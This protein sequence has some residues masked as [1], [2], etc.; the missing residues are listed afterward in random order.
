MW[1]QY[2]NVMSFAFA[3]LRKTSDVNDQMALDLD[4]SLI[5]FLSCELMHHSLPS[6]SL[7][8]TGGT[9]A[10]KFHAVLHSIFLESGSSGASLISF[11]K[12]ICACTTDL[13]T[14]FALPLVR[15]MPVSSVFPWIQTEQPAG[16]IATDADDFDLLQMQDFIPT[17]VS[18]SSSLAFPGL[19]HIIHNAASEVL[20][21]TEL[22]ESQV[23][24]LAKVCNLLADG[25][26]C[27]KMC[28]TCYNSSTGQQ[29]QNKLKEFSC[30]VY[31]PRWGSVAF[32][33]RSLLDVKSVLQWGWSLEK[34]QIGGGKVGPE[35]EAADNAIQSPLF[36]ASLLVLDHLYELIR[37]CFRWSEGCPCHSD[38]QFDDV[39]KEVR[40]R[41]ESCPLRGLRVP[42][43][44][45]GDF[46]AVFEKLQNEATVS[47]AASLVYVSA[48]DKGKLLQEFE[49]G[50]LFLLH[51]FTLK[52]SAFSTP[53]LLL[54]AVA[55]HSKLVA[56]DSIRICLACSDEHPKIKALQVDPLK[57]QAE[58]Y[59][60]GVDLVELPEL[61]IFI[62]GLRFCHAVERRVEGGHAK[63]LRRGRSATQHTEAFDSLALRISE[64]TEKL[65][66]NPDFLQEL[67]DVIDRARSPKEL[68]GIL[69]FKNHPACCD[70]QLHS[71][72]KLYRQIVYRADMQTLYHIKPP[73]LALKSC[74]PDRQCEPGPPQQQLVIADVDALYIT[75]LRDAAL[76]FFHFQL[77][78]LESPKTLLIYSCQALPPASTIL[79][80]KKLKRNR[81]SDLPALPLMLP[82]WLPENGKVWFSIISTSPH[83]SKRAGSGGLVSTDLAIAVHESLNSEDGF[84]YVL[85]TAV[86][87]GQ[88]SSESI[89]AEDVPLILTT[90]MFDLDALK[91][92]ECWEVHKEL[93]YVLDTGLRP[94]VFDEAASSLAEKMMAS[95]EFQLDNQTS[96]SD[97]LLL[98]SWKEQG[99]VKTYQNTVGKEVCCFSRN[100]IASLKTCW[101]LS[102]RC[103]VLNV[104]E[105]PL[106][107][108]TR[109][110]LLCLLEKEGWLMGTAGSGRKLE[111]YVFGSSEPL[112][113]YIKRGKDA[114]S[115]PLPYL[116]LLLNAADHGK[117]VPHLCAPAK[118]N[119]LLETDIQLALMPSKRKHVLQLEFDDWGLLVPK[120][121][122]RR[123]RKQ[124]ADMAVDSLLALINGDDV[125]HVDS[126]E[127]ASHD[128]SGSDM[129][130]ACDD[131]AAGVVV[132]S[133]REIIPKTLT[134]AEQGAEVRESCAKESSSLSS[135]SSDSS[136]DST[137]SS[138]DDNTTAVGRQERTKPVTEKKI[139]QQHKKT[140]QG[141]NWGLC[142]LTPRFKAKK[143]S[144]Y[145]MFCSRPE[146][147]VER[148]C[149]K[150][151][152]FGVAGG[153]DVCRRM[154]KSWIVF[155]A[156][157]S[158]RDEHM[159][160][161]WKM[162]L[163]LK[164]DL[165]LPFEVLLDENTVHDWDAYDDVGRSQRIAPPAPQDFLPGERDRL[166]S[167]APG[168]PESVHAEMEELAASGAVPITTQKQRSRNKKTPGT[169]YGV[170]PWL[171]DAVKY[172]YVHP[173]LPP[174]RGCVWRFSSGNTW[175]L[176]FKGG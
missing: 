166:G 45:A 11:C 119:Q 101:K 23:D 5:D 113:W 97:S 115:I 69:G 16:I 48:A 20:T 145:Q 150:E 141:E 67:S 28:E 173:N 40:K 38:L 162:I 66:S 137:D 159:F 58:E 158:S 29:L 99:F 27:M 54:G 59:L 60:N 85:S 87:L 26:S 118:Y 72:D 43:V 163:N 14:E 95:P 110:E 160:S 157:V 134:V 143:L 17:E 174:P 154:L 74:Q 79:L 77:K 51:T 144:G 107:D 63:V 132:A 171:S 75:V 56:H 125:E 94:L 100:G 114:T 129:I 83:R 140:L 152:S 42:E 96:L 70:V 57:W 53:P 123:P 34:Y 44:C 76:S 82:D 165:A 64:I 6:T 98:Q 35:L 46:F 12:D 52:L 22:L 146:H 19:L 3:Q 18:L 112:V 164:K 133:G 156:G 61:G 91:N 127:N 71:W 126:G 130:D 151:L 86:N 31:R 93:H 106:E 138:E 139:I 169:T 15:P 8:G 111:P 89:A 10:Q 78:Q 68:V 102:K 62:A 122:Q 103:Q 108:L 148:R 131:Q 37:S 33:C 73:S 109:Y 167:A 175:T 153:E 1:Q 24:N 92:A 104:R 120:L 172:N 136:Q 55:H 2:Q 147:N 128:G 117:A 155:G 50:R 21:V 170:P 13:G 41:W 88:S 105:L 161:C 135:S 80:S 7:G 90:H 81:G 36:W 65:D 25:Q 9:L 32:C 39:S 176:C 47:L 142:L 121:K 30:R 4:E 168:V 49:R 84:G 124:Q 149:T 116:R